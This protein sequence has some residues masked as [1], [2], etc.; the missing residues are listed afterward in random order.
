MSSPVQ[1]DVHLGKQQSWVPYS[2]L[3]F[4][5]ILS[6]K[7]YYICEQPSQ[8]MWLIVLELLIFSWQEASTRFLIWE[9][10]LV[11]MP[12]CPHNL[13]CISILSHIEFTFS[14]YL[15]YL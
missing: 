7:E 13:C 12:P 8:K 11:P 2:L 6:I 1:Q 10:L 3:Y 14:L 15:L 5:S 9:F 4:V